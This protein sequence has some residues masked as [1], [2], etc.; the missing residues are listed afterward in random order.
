LTTTVSGTD[1]SVPT[2]PHSQP[3]FLFDRSGVLVWRRSG[4][5]A[6]RDDDFDRALAAALAGP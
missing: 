2:G 1:S 6:E 5:I 3:S 4:A